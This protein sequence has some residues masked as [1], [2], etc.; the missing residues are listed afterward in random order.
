[1]AFAICVGVVI[2]QV[3]TLF[4]HP[5]L[6]FADG[7]RIVGIRNWDVAT[8]QPEPR[9]LHDFALWG[10]TLSTV[11]DLGAWID[12]SRN[13]IVAEGDARPVQ[14][15]EITAPGFVSAKASRCSAA[16]W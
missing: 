16:R 9:A 13:L 1:M 11:T 4:T 3:V 5:T 14:V 6:P 12:A 2:F 10:D 7:E 15:A 8:N